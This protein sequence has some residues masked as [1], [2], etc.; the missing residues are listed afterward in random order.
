MEIPWGECPFGRIND[1]YPGSCF[2]YT[3]SDNN[4]ICDRS[5]PPPS[6]RNILG[7]STYNSQLYSYMWALYVP[8]SL[9]FVYWY[10]V[11]KTNFKQ[12]SAF[13]T[14]KYFKLFWNVVLLI[15]FIT[16]SVTAII[17]IISPNLTANNVHKYSG[18]VMIVVAALHIVVRRTFF[19]GFIKKF[20]K[21]VSDS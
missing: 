8:I 15:L 7:N 20:T 1:E 2:R 13:F 17:Q 14:Q 5:E 11:E 18:L 4:K 6:D 19:Q 3:D 21:K 10:V 9:Y 16:S 12:K